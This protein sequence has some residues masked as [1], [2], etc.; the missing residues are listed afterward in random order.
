MRFVSLLARISSSM[1]QTQQLSEKP[2]IINTIN[3]LTG[4]YILL[5]FRMT[6]YW[7]LLF[8]FVSGKFGGFQSQAGEKNPEENVP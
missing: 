3:T 6:N 5:T 8:M 4:K 7:I 1:I 2:Q